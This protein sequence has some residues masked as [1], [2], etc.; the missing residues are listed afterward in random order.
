MK[1]RKLNFMKNFC[2]LFLFIIMRLYAQDIDHIKKKLNEVGLSPEQAKQMA[3]QKGYSNSQ[4]ENEAKSRGINLNSIDSSDENENLIENNT[5]FSITDSYII[6]VVAEE[7]EDDGDTHDHGEEHHELGF[8]LT[9]LSAGTTT[10]TLS[11]MHED[12]ADYTSLPIT[13]TV[14]E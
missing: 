5:S 14:T 12:H 10:F 13:V 3:K 1:I 4:I 6:S 2:T 7:H 11:L 9:G 8:E